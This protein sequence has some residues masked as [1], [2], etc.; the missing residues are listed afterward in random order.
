M[1]LLPARG[2]L[3]LCMM[4][5]HCPAKD[6]CYH[7]PSVRAI[8]VGGHQNY[9]ETTPRPDGPCEAWRALKDWELSAVLRSRDD[10]E[11][12]YITADQV[13]EHRAAGWTV[14]PFTHHHGAAGYWL[15]TREA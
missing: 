2:A 3:P 11:A 4:S 15:A 1:T 6:R 12:L 14:E 7:S 13:D 9:M 8:A 10:G 5:R